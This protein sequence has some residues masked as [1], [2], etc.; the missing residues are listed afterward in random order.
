MPVSAVKPLLS[1]TS[2][3]AGSQAAQPRVILSDLALLEPNIAI[4][5]EVISIKNLFF[6]IPLI[7][8]LDIMIHIIALIKR[9]ISKKY[10]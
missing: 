1:S 9:Q 7:V 8:M 5:K 10:Y 3:F 6:I 2:A 4:I